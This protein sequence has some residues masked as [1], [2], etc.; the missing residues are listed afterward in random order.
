MDQVETSAPAST[1][2][3]PAAQ[4]DDTAERQACLAR[5][6]AAVARGF[7]RRALS[8]FLKLRAALR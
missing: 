4:A 3:A 5:L 6:A 2:D 1:T 7:D 8:E